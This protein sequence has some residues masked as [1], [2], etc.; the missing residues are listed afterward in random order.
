[1]NYEEFLEYIK[2]SAQEFY[3][4]E[5]SVTINHVMKNNGIGLDG[6]AIMERDTN[7][8]PTIYLNN[9]YEEYRHGLPMPEIM[10][11]IIQIYDEAKMQKSFD[12]TFYT[13][14]ESVKKRIVYKLINRDKNE[15]LL[16]QIPY[17]EVL[18]LVMVYYCMVDN[19]VIG[20]VTIMV[21]NDHMRM[22]KTDESELYDIARQNT[23]RILKA[24]IFG[25]KE[26]LCE[27]MSK[28]LMDEN[29]SE[30][31]EWIKGA[32]QE[33]YPSD[34]EVPM[35][36]L[37]N[38]FRVNGA[39]CMLYSDVLKEFSGKHQKN[40]YVIPSSVH[41]VILVPADES[42]EGERLNE[43]L[44]EVNETQVADEEILSGKVYFYD[45][46]KNQLEQVK[47]SEIKNESVF[48]L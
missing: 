4:E 3:G 13:D 43:M 44:N 33:E 46:N 39:A 30:D 25:M 7:I 17:R 28:Q 38:H 21:N 48:V 18:D 12:M 41:E 2:K 8:S 10:M 6:L 37:T 11:R 15:N 9:F 14:F 26:I 35:Y 40:L 19:D 16:K 22:W 27:I 5:V 31:E 29:K 34:E 47:N 1:M 24:E 32:L 23:E 20:S 42:I 36:I 45:Y